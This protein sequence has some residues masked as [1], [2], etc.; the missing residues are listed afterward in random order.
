MAV[1]SVY[2]RMLYVFLTGALIDQ[3]SQ[4]LIDQKPMI[5]RDLEIRISKGNRYMKVWWHSDILWHSSNSSTMI[6]DHGW[7]KTIG[8]YE[9]YDHMTIGSEYSYDI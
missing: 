1:I 8:S 4:K 7:L 3:N 2:Y 9:P 5:I 6:T